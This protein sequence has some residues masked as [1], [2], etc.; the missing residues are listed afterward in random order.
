MTTSSP[1]KD[2][3][4]ACVVL[5]D[6]EAW[7]GNPSPSYLDIFLKGAQFRAG[8]TQPALH[9]WKIFG[10]LGNSAF[11]EPLVAR[12][13]HPTLSIRWPSA[14]EMIHFQV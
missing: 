8:L 1:S 11:S 6:C 7:L 3:C 4:L 5:D 13:G 10:P 9:T 12:T 2:Q 14:L